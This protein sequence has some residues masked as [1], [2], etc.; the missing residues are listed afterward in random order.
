MWCGE[1]ESYG[2]ST[3]TRYGTCFDPGHTSAT[4]AVRPPEVEW[5]Y[6][7]ATRVPIR[8]E[9]RRPS[10]QPP[11]R[12]VLLF[13]DATIDLASNVGEDVES[14]VGL[15]RRKRVRASCHRLGLEHLRRPVVRN[16]RRDD[17]VEV[18][19]EPDDV[20][21]PQASTVDVDL[22]RAAI[23]APEPQRLAGQEHDRPSSAT[24]RFDTFGSTFSRDRAPARRQEAVALPA[25]LAHAGRG[26]GDPAGLLS[27]AS[28]TRSCSRAPCSIEVPR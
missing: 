21:R 4:D 12:R 15:A 27:A 24:L 8:R 11:V 18:L 14:A 9:P 1:I 23:A 16:L 13:V 6:V 26:R 22:D 3:P 19:L 17:A 10:R 5:K 7:V 25:G 20:D 28:R 2:S